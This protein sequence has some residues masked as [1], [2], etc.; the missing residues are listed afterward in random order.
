LSLLACGGG[1]TIGPQNQPQVTNAVDDFQFQASNLNNV[2]QTILYTWQNTG[3]Q[4]NVNQAATIT[5]GSAT[6]RI[7]DSSGTQVYSNSLAANGTV[8]T[9]AG[10]TGN[11]AI[12]VVLSNVSGTINFR[13]Q[14]RP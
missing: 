13:V 11:W 8:A 6:L 12:E 2:T 3:T 7:R 4:A 5:A 9:S 10:T 1:G 14:K